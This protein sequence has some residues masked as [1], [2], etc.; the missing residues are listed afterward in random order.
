MKYAK[1]VGAEL[2]AELGA[3]VGLCTLGI[4]LLQVNCVAAME[5]VK[6]G[7]P[8]LFKN[9]RFPKG[10]TQGTPGIQKVPPIYIYIYIFHSADFPTGGSPMMD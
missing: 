6:Y 9:V 3:E 1:H 8:K 4:E 5:I 7:L 2:G 10:N